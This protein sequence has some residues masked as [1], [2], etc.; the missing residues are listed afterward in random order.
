MNAAN[1]MIQ[2][3]DEMHGMADAALVELDRQDEVLDRI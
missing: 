3:V 1:R 2:R